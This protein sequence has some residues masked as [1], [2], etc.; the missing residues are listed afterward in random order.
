MKILAFLFLLLIAALQYPIWLGKGGWLQVRALQQEIDKQ[1]ATNVL[2][3]ARNDA[4]AAEVTDLKSGLEAVEERARAEL[5]M[6][7]KD[8]IFFQ[9]QAHRESEVRN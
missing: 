5:G 9:F 6:V 1:Q 2:L 8:E 4:L 3:K 7:K